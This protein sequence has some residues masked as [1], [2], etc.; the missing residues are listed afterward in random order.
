LG[1]YAAPAGSTL[2]LHINYTA[3][4]GRNKQ[5]LWR[6]A[7]YPAPGALGQEVVALV[8]EFEMNAARTV[9][10]CLDEPQHKVGVSLSS[11]A[12]LLTAMCSPQA[13]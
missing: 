4:F 13:D 12:C 9:L 3:A 5:G 10:P 2:L 11:S 1:P 6:S 8:S 7:A